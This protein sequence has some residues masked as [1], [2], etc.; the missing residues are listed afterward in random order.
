LPGHPKFD[1]ADLIGFLRVLDARL[2]RPGRIRLIGG[3]VVG[4]CFLPSYRTRDIDYAWADREVQ[5]AIAEVR[6]EQPHLVVTA[7]TG[8]YF[9]PYSYERRLQVLDIP[10]LTYL[11]VEVPER[12]DLAVMKVARGFDRDLEALEQMHA[13]EP[14]ELTTLAQRFRE[15]W[16]TGPQRHADL[17]FLSF[18]EVLFGEAGAVR[19]EQLLHDLGQR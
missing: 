15:T 7:Q 16:V 18:V 14:F 13:V 2:T 17:A 6:A 12:H 10:G 4:L 3:A 11:T 9:A 1:R 5:E 19:A 8:V